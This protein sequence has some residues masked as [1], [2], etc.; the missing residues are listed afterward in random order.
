MSESADL[1]LDLKEDLKQ[2]VDL[3]SLGDALYLGNLSI[4]TPNSQQ[5]KVAFD[6][7]SEFLVVTSVFCSD[8]TSPEKYRFKK[9]DAHSK[10]YKLRKNDKKRCLNQAYNMTASQ[11][12]HIRSDRARR[13]TYGSADLQGFQFEDYT[14]L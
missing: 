14:C 8:E 10:E 7:G 1:S 6:T 5:I 13:V 9:W 3:E 11:S 2:R 12:A 4:G